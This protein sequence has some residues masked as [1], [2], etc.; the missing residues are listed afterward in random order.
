[1]DG[2]RGRD[3]TRSHKSR[4]SNVNGLGEDNSD[5][6]AGPGVG[7]ADYRYTDIT[8]L[9]SPEELGGV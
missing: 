4:G 9:S 2:P 5:G 3:D 8:R 7:F 6:R 1:M